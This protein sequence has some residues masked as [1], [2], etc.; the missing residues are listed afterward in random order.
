MKYT[1]RHAAAVSLLSLACFAC[2]SSLTQAGAQIREA[3]PPRVAQCVFLGTVVGHVGRFHP[4][5]IQDAETEALNAAAGKGATHV[6]WVSLTGAT[7]SARAYRCS[8]G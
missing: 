2:G 6:V 7:A 1:H 3:D 8:G 4:S 5:P